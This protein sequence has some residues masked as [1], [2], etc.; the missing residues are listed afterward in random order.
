MIAKTTPPA[1]AMFKAK[2]YEY[3]VEKLNS[4]LNVQLYQELGIRHSVQYYIVAVRN[5]FVTLLRVC[6]C[7]SCVIFCRVSVT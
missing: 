6:C 2:L 3:Y 1:C 5:L 7:C 4:G